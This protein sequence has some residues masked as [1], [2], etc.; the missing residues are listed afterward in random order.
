ME[1]VMAGKVPAL[2]VVTVLV[3]L[4]SVPGETPMTLTLTRH[5]DEAGTPIDTLMKLGS[6]VEREPIP[7]VPPNEPPPPLSCRPAGSVSVNATALTSEPVRFVSVNVSVEVP[8]TEIEAG[9]KDFAS[10]RATPAVGRSIIGPRRK[11]RTSTEEA[12][13]E[14]GDV[15]RE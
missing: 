7:H 12:T 9:E 8:P 1:A 15:L 14:R 5:V 6:D 3:V 11:A 4:T 2:A 13:T 10:D